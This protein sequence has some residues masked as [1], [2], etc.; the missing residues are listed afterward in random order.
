MCGR[1]AFRPKVGLL[2]EG[3]RLFQEE[4]KWLIYA[5]YDGSFIFL[6]QSYLYLKDPPAF[7][8]ASEFQAQRQLLGPRHPDVCCTARR[9]AKA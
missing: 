2:D 7:D 4:A 8:S 3:L 6:L 9:M 5:T 1:Q